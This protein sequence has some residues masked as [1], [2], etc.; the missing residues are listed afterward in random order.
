MVELG[1]SI[2]CFQKDIDQK[3]KELKKPQGYDASKSWKNDR[4]GRWREEE[5]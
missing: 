1:F 2:S 5:K 3:L 4:D